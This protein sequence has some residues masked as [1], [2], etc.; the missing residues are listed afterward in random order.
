MK[1]CIAIMIVCLIAVLTNPVKAHAIDVVTGNNYFPYSDERL[2]DGGLGTLLVKAIIEKMGVP[3][4]VAFLP[5]DEGYQQTLS[6]RYVATFPYIKTPEREADFLYSDELFTVRPY[7][8]TNFER[9]T[10]VT[11][12]SDMIGKTLCVPKGW[13]VDAYLSEYAKSGQ[14]RVYNKT[15]VGG[16]FKLLSEGKVD[17]VSIDRFLGTIAARSINSAPWF[18]ARRLAIDASPN[19]LI[20]PKSMPGADRWIARFNEARQELRNDGTIANLTNSYF[21][22]YKQD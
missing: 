15:G 1:R 7:L 2:P 17:A 13:E 19:Y 4:T 5:W 14:M 10:G 18:K 21:E 16:C 6:G 9:A 20:V 12:A 8:F 22:A 3:V 11:Q